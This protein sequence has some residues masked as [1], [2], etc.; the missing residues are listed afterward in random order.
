MGE[1]S[2][3]ELQTLRA[4]FLVSKEEFAKEMR[5]QE[6]VE[7]IMRDRAERAKQGNAAV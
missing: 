1:I 3:A 7:E 4:H 5:Y 6:S 2:F